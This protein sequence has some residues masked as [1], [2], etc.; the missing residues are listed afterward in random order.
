MVAC[1]TISAVKANRLFWLGRYV[2]RAY[3]NLHLLRRYYDR[4]IDG[5]PSMYEEYYRKLDAQG[6]RFRHFL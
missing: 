3:L 2:E 4:M 1:T 6:S 5:D